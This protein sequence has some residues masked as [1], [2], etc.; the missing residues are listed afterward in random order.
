MSVS[1]LLLVLTHAMQR[2]QLQ[3]LLLVSRKAAVGNTVYLQER[4]R[5]RQHLMPHIPL[6][7][8]KE[9]HLI[10]VDSHIT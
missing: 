5:C 4:A 8:G 9:S 2:V 10:R 7:W 6:V 3:Q 1:V